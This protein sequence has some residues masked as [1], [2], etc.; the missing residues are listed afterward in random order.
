M[1]EDVIPDSQ[2]PE[3]ELEG[4]EEMAALLTEPKRGVTAKRCPVN[5]QRIK[6]CSRGL[7]P[8]SRWSCRETDRGMYR[9][10]NPRESELRNG[11]L[12]A[13]VS[14]GSGGGTSARVETQRSKQRRGT[15]ECNVL[16]AGKG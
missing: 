12:A 16:P 7:S 13:E 9:H 6:R 11:R 8:R 1:L 2:G 4:E 15:G 10:E 5:R 14:S 3:S